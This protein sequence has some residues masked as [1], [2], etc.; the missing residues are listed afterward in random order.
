MT[1]KERIE[2]AL[3][4]KETDRL[5]FGM[6]MHYP[7]RD[8]MPRRL[9][10]LSIHYQEELDL[11]FIKFMPYGMHSTIDWGAELDV[12]PGFADPPVPHGAV[13][14]RPEDWDKITPRKGTEGEYAV[15][16]EA[17]RLCL[18]MR[19]SVVPFVQTAFSPL[20]TAAKLATEAVLIDHIRTC[21][22]RVKRA[23]E[24]ITETTMQ[25]VNA[26]VAGGADGFFFA[27]Q[28]STTKLTPEEHAEFVRAYDLPILESIKG[29]TWF[30]ILHVHGANTRI[31]EM[32]DYPVQA[33]NWHD[34]DDGPSIPE[35]RSL[36]NKLALIGGLS[37]LK[38]I[39]TGTDAEV[40]AQVEAAWKNGRGVILGPGCVA[41]SSTP[42]SRLRFISACVRATAQK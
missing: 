9:A 3:A 40:K 29:K 8:R 5:P 33:V 35:V 42:D 4:Q 30:N 13:V 32:L 18:S 12:F 15:I 21:P 7:N 39:T 17:Q 10:E 24:V 6:W 19:K 22:E 38:T 14:T 25:Y 26:G 41:S 31:R 37:H 28:M 2:S 20:T 34:Q 23:L 27:T 36:T 1:H 11:D 16:L